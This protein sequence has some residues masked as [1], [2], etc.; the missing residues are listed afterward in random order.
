M[1]IGTWATTSPRSTSAKKAAALPSIA[2]AV[3]KAGIPPVAV[4][5]PGGDPISSRFEVD[6]DITDNP[7][8]VP[9]DWSTVNCDGGTAQVKT[10][11]NDGLGASIF[12]QGGSKD[13]SDIGVVKNGVLGQGW[14][15]TNG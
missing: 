9:E 3:S 2:S 12:T 14:M 1:F 7:A 6:G 11:V 5:T 10:F 15:H 8:G 4:P 13:P